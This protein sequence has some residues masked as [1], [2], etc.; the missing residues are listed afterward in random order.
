MLH[1]LATYRYNISDKLYATEHGVTGNHLSI[2]RPTGTVR[3]GPA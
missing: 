3:D 1:P 2:T